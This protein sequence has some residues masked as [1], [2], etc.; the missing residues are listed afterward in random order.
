MS[1]NFT[2]GL[3]PKIDK[4]PIS[5]DPVE[6]AARMYVRKYPAPNAEAPRPK[7][8]GGADAAPAPKE[9]S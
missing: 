4:P 6:A 3:V 7:A 1:T 2:D 8:G 5:E 9:K